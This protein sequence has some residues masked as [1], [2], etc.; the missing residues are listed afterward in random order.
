VLFVCL[1][2]WLVGWLIVWLVGC[3]VGGLEVWLFDCLFV[4]VCVF[5]GLDPYSTM[6]NVSSDNDFLEMMMALLVEH[7]FGLTPL[8]FGSHF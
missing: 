5:L 1:F 7:G 4:R 2:G 6:M 8:G 3:L